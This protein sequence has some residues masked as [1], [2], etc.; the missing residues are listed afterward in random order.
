MRVP[1]KNRIGNSANE[2][3]IARR[4]RSTQQDR[5]RGKRGRHPIPSEFQ[6][7]RRFRVASSARIPI[8]FR[9]PE[10][11][12]SAILRGVSAVS[13]QGGDPIFPSQSTIRSPSSEPCGRVPSAYKGSTFC[14]KLCCVPAEGKWY[15]GLPIMIP[16][17]DDGLGLVN[18]DVGLARSGR[19][20]GKLSVFFL[21]TSAHTLSGFRLSPVRY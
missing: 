2:G 3:W 11:G 5:Q 10:E 12:P 1:E 20:R 6:L 15:P 13:E 4:H 9:R 16:H 7:I 21:R 17:N 8:A 18:G 19:E 14:W